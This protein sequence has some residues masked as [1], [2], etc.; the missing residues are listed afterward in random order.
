MKTIVYLLLS[1][2]LLLSSCGERLWINPFDPQCPKDIWTPTNFQAIQEGITVKLTWSQPIP[3]ISGFKI[4]KSVG[5]TNTTLPDQSVSSSQL[6]DATPT[7]GQ[8]NIYVITAYAGNSIS[9]SV[10]VQITP[11]LPST[12]TTA[13]PTSITGIA[14]VVGG[15]ITT[16]GGS[17]ITTR[18]I[19]WATTTAPTTSSNKLAIGS[20]TG[21]FSA[22]ITAL[23]PSTTYYF[24]AYAINSQGTAYGNQVQATTLAVL[25][26]LTTTAVSLL[27]S[28]SFTSGGTITSDGGATVTARGLC[29]SLTQ[30]PT[31][32]NNKTT[33]GSGTGSFT[34]SITGLNPATTYYIRAYATNSVGTE[35]GSQVTVTTL[36]ALPTI[37]TTAIS[38]FTS[39]TATGGGNITSN[40]GATVTASGIC[41][42]TTQNPTT[43]NTK[44][45]ATIFS[46]SFTSSITGLTPGTTYYVRAYATNSIGTIY[47]NEISFTTLAVLPTVSTTSA[48][49]IA[50]TSFTSGGN[51]T[52]N[53]GATIT[54][55]GI[56]YSTSQNPTISN[57]ITSD[58]PGSGTFT[59]SITG[60]SPV[61]TYYIRAYA[62]NSIGTAYGSQLTVTTTVGLAILTTTSITS[63]GTTSAAGGG[64]ITNTGGTSVTA[65][66]VCWSTAINPTI[67]NTKS[68]NGSG[69]G[70][71]T[72]ALSGLT[73]KTT[74]YVRAYATNSTGTSYGT[75]VSFTTP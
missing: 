67:A 1:I 43:S 37:T 66:G 7:G 33:D 22:S 58:G 34:S 14:M 28:T 61:T 17:P 15:T 27:A 72:S 9:N 19:C 64:N 31:I 48:S 62:T 71:F 13:N 74:Y 30:T 44:I 75:Q 39:T 46:G 24:R 41:L 18:G 69:A 40:G 53:G 29:Y 70:I 20:G 51:I 50:S 73:T 2:M 35:Y 59:S 60:L 57:S 5:S 68:S 10:T 11:L 26:S 49:S 45:S 16:D 55:G 4:Q 32:S 8:P 63:I 52:N 21:T 3:N 42:A 47:G 54:A 25:P 23:S 6:I 56:C 38:V 36:A 65:R 12:L